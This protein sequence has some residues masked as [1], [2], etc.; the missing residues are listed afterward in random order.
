MTK[1]PESLMAPCLSLNQLSRKIHWA[2]VEAG[3]WERNSDGTLV[4]RNVGE[5]LCLVHSEISG[6][7]EGHRKDLDDDHLPHRKMFE[8]ELADAL[9]RIFDIAGAFNLN[10]ADA[11]YEKALYNAHRADH[12]KEA[13]EAVGGKK[14]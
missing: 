13:R 8:V 5:L 2:N 7:M 4:P 9:I 6:A 1:Y 10:L 14:Y 12:K 3:W 11:L